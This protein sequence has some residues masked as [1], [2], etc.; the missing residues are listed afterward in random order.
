MG[1]K[2]SQESL[3]QKF[4][5]VGVLALLLPRNRGACTSGKTGVRTP[6]VILFGI[7]LLLK[8]DSLCELGCRL[9]GEANV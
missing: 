3:G 6:S 5:T 2:D 7:A 8:L 9:K 4:R 1:G